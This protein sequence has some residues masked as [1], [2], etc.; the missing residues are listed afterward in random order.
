MC[1]PVRGCVHVSGCVCVWFL[2]GVSVCRFVWVVFMYMV[3][4]MCMVCVCI[5]ACCVCIYGVCVC[6]W[7][8]CMCVHVPYCAFGD[9]TNGKKSVLFPACGCQGL[10]SFHHEALGP[11][12]W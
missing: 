10:R 12:A 3:V 9:N 8:V 2:Y 7:C 5:Y 6:V 4:C 11:Q 1:V